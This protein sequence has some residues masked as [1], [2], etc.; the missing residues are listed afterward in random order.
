MPTP[1]DGRP[2]WLEEK[3][4]EWCTRMHLEDDHPED[5]YHQD[6][7]TIVPSIVAVLECRTMRRVAH[8]EELVIQRSQWP[9]D[10]QV[11][12]SVTAMESSTPSLT[13][14][15]DCIPLLLAALRARLGNSQHESAG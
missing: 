14:A 10:P 15:V 12:V 6:D 2:T 9:S 3:C 13:V 11:W 4:P 1:S 5:R 7:G 8:P